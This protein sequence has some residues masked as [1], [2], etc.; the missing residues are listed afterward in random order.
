MFL[1]DTTELKRLIRVTKDTDSFYLEKRGI[2]K[3][4]DPTG[5]YDFDA[6]KHHLNA[7]V[8]STY[9]NLH[10]ELLYTDEQQNFDD[11]MNAFAEI[12]EILKD[13]NE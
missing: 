5:A 1:E 7:Q 8:K 9:E 3:E 4:Y 10:K 11:A 6:W 12:N 2:S 13:I